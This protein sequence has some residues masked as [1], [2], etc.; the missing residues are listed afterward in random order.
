MHKRKPAFGKHLPLTCFA[1]LMLSFTAILAPAQAAPKQATETIA[2]RGLE[3]PADILIDRWGVPHIYAKNE[4]DLFFAQGFN[5][6]RD[7]LFQI[8]LWR[9]RGLRSSPGESCRRSPATPLC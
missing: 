5:A 8:D 9:R 2:I 1:L 7:R 4:T 3:Q 6:A